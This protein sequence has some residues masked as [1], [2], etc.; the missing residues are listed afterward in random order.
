[1]TPK[2]IHDRLKSALGDRLLEF[3]EVRGDPFA[4][5]AP[6]ALT[7]A[8]RMLRDEPELAMDMLSDQCGSDLD[9]EKPLESVYH[10]TSLKHGHTFTL[11]VR[12]PRDHPRCPSLVPLY[13]S[14]NLFERETYDLYGIVYEGHP[15]LRRI[16]LPDDWQGWP[17]RKDYEMPEWHNEVPLIHK[18]DIQGDYPGLH[19]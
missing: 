19:P 6:E 1:M 18:M 3:S 16:L 15:D 4:V 5:A 14:A 7:E 8:A 11:K 10:F 12:L 2:A 9:P 13:G 17:M